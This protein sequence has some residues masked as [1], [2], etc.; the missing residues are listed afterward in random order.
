MGEMGA[1][2]DPSSRRANLMVRGI[3]L[4]ET[5]GRILAISGV[6][7]RIHGETRPCERMVE[8]LDGLRGAMRSSWRGGAF[9]EVLYDGK[10]AVG[11]PVAWHNTEP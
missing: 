7:I 4:Y 5:R 10:I 9:G 1:E 3:D 8:A 11:D 6:R 2:T